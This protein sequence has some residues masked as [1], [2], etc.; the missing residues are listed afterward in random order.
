ML[1]L[2]R[3]KILLRS[4][5]FYILIIFFI[6][7]YVYINVFYVRYESLYNGNE[8]SII[9]KVKEYK[10]DDDKI[11]LTIKSDEL[12]IVYYYFN[13][14]YLEID[15]IYGKII[16]VEGKMVEPSNNTIPNTFNYKEYLYNNKMHYTFKADEISILSSSFDIRNMIVNKLDSYKSK[17]YMYMFILG[18]KSHIS[19]EIYNSFQING[20][21]HL[22]A[23]SG[24]HI[25]LFILI[26]VK[27]LR[28]FKKVKKNFLIL[29]FLVVYA[30]ITSYTVSVLRC[31]L[32]Y[33]LKL[34]NEIFDL[35]LKNINLLILTACIL[36][37]FKPFYIYDTGFRYSFIITYFLFLI[38]NKK[39]NFLSNSFLISLIA[40]LASFPITININYEINII[41]ILL[42]LFFV[43]LVSFII[44]PFALLTFIFPFL[45]NIFYFIT[46][47]LELSS[48]F[49][50]NNIALLIN[51][52]L[53]SNVI[54]FLYYISLYLY[55]KY[56]YKY[57]ILIVSIVFINKMIYKIDS[58]Y[59]VYYI[60]VGQGD[61]NILISPYQKEV[62]MIDTG[63]NYFY[64]VSDNVILF[65]KSL[66][67]K[68]I[69]ILVITHGD[70]DHALETENLYN[71][72][73]IKNIMFNLNEYNQL[74]LS[75]K[76]L[77]IPEI[78]FI[79][80]KYFKSYNLNQNIYNEND[81]SVVLQFNLYG[82]IFLYTGDIGSSA[83]TQLV[84]KYKLSSDFYK[85]SHHGS[86][87]NTT[88]YIIKQIDPK[89][90][91]ISAG[92]NNL[93]DHP[94]EEVL[95]I[96]A[97]NNVDF[98]STTVDGSV[99]VKVSKKNYHIYNFPA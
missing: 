35:E 52:P 79:N 82:Y 48:L 22:F 66:G 15:N 43:P 91:V 42:N 95:K 40:F 68:A 4:K 57:L 45:D 55:M 61:C 24:L 83:L 97:S 93:Y 70:V 60:D 19:E 25:N 77:N 87:N 81:A 33:I 20:I 17:S 80:L 47:V 71:N 23:I 88:D 63:G 72:L 18:D 5:I 58:N 78:E 62:V 53:M 94:N 46:N 86:K 75:I 73:K 2:I 51:I 92:N 54:V 76:K 96:L 28:K 85:V 26:L 39:R 21:L 59:Y 7:L 16:K 3:L 49:C 41:S 31:I 98:Y 14:Q 56:N 9:G 38:K 12:I 1:H 36:L 27:L 90:A 44:F 32:F 11:I 50:S 84:D 37:L 65:L 13:D 69:D 30:Y 74:E 6:S 67:I 29:S 89:Y 99:M 8:V 64:N 34:I 10:V